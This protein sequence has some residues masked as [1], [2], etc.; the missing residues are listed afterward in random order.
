MQTGIVSTTW[1][2][3]HLND[4]NLII[5]DATIKKVIEPDGIILDMPK[6]PNSI[7]FDI[8]NKFSDQ[9][10][11][12]PNTFPSET[13]FTEEC[14]KLGI[15]KDSIII[16]Y[17]GL[18]IYSSPRVWFLFKAMGHQNVAV[19]D[20]GSLAWASENRTTVSNYADVN[21]L[22]DFEAKFDHNLLVN[23][24]EVLDALNDYED[25]IVMDARS[26]PRFSGM[27][28]EPRPGLRNGHMPNSSSLPY[29]DLLEK[30]KFKSKEALQH[31]FDKHYIEDRNIIF[32]CGSG[33]TACILILAYHQ[34][35]DKKT[36]LYD[37][38][39]TDWALNLELP[40]ENIEMYM[41][42]EEEYDDDDD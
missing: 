14:R 27:I 42:T 6:I 30:G 34:I 25:M 37:G 1:L 13:M 21:T 22:G 8:K 19:L 10:A 15:N 7:L 23:S 11:E 3:D 31:I 36:Q 28:K 16:V 32:S 24:D 29:T 4:K 5:L 18:G 35:S 17:D 39:W 12:L 26:N 40:I 2:S 9:S 33:I 20:G 38:S 41:P